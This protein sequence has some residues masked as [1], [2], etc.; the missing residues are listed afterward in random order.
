MNMGVTLA[1]Y[2]TLCKETGQP[3]VYPG[4][5][6]QWNFLTDVTDARILAEQLEW[7][8]TTPAAYGHAFNI[9]NGDQFRWRWLWPQLAAYFGVE[10][11]GPPNPLA[12]L[13]GRMQTAAETWRTI[14]AKHQ[15]VEPDIDKL[16]SWW[17]TDGDL[18][19]TIE[20]VND[21]TQSRLL[22]FHA[23]QPTP[24]SFFDLFGRLKA[25]HIIPD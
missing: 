12:P 18:G 23:F 1:V 10:S 6:E 17:H 3:F 5:P 22:G 2:A 14:A 7:A 16:V 21:M 8:A 19:R 9:S 24:A 15:L 11:Q 4:S 13:E 20:C 25:E